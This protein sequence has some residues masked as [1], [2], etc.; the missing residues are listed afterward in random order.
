M[1][2]LLVASPSEQFG[3][4]VAGAFGDQL[5]GHRRYWREGLFDAEKSAIVAELT[6]NNPAVVAIGP[7]IDPADALELAHAFD[8]DRPDVVVVLVAKPS[9]TLL[10]NAL[11]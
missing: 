11:R 4:K 10:E 3:A 7:D 6:R 1:S 9:I 2:D 8:A 5:N